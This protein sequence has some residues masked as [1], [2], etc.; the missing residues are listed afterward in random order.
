L[1]IPAEQYPYSINSR[2]AFSRW[3]DGG[4]MTHTIAS[5]PAKSASYTATVTPEYAPV[6]NF[7]YP[8]CGGTASLTPASPTNDGFYPTEQ[9]LDF[10]A[11]ADPGWTFAGWTF[12]LT[13][14]E[15]PATLTA[16]GET[17]VFANFNT[18]STPLTLTSI[19]PAVTRAGGTGFTLTV[20][21]TGFVKA[22]QG[23]QGTVVSVNGQY[24][25]VDFVSPTKL[26]VPVTAAEIA[27]PGAIQVAVENYP[28]GSTGCAVFGYQMLLVEGKGAPAATPVY[29]PKAGKY[30]SP[31][32][33][34]IT[35]A[36]AGATIYY[37]T[38]GTTPTPSSPV[39]STPISVSATETL[40]ADATAPGYVRSAVT[41]GVYTITP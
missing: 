6:T 4:A 14:D 5:L 35:T 2:Y 20:T 7:N 10:S 15:N 19:T 11:T 28:F 13:G 38:D 24:P 18:T 32:M 1:S 26:T 27:D 17:L 31:Q 25:T 12:D 41:T 29:S 37:T 3:S 36:L 34:T 40:K 33:V 39:Y 23:V 9:V 21:G 22:A 8:P 30:T 16:K